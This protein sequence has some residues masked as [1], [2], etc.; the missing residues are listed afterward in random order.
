M[1]WIFPHGEGC[2][3]TSYNIQGHGIEVVDKREQ[4]S[5]PD[6]AAT[7]RILRVELQGCKEEN[8]ILVK[9]LVEQNQLTTTML[10]SLVDLQRLINYGH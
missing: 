3:R 8:K 10:H 7:I 4:E 2:I 5:S 9:D 1:R 6:A